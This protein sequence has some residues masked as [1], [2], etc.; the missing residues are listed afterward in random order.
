MEKIIVPEKLK[1]NTVYRVYFDRDTGDIFSI[2]N[3]FDNGDFFETDYE[4]VKYLLSG[5]ERIVDYKVVYNIRKIQYEIVSKD[6]FLIDI[7][8]ND[9]IYKVPYS[10]KF[11]IKI[12]QNIKEKKWVF[13]LNEETKV[14]LENTNARLNEQLFFSVTQRDNPNILYRTFFIQIKDLVEN[15]FC[16]FEFVD[17]KRETTDNVSVYTNRKFQSYSHEVINE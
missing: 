14:I 7:S 11:Q 13:L 1:L 6:K 17:Q 16:S 3:T 15:Q 2:T 5:N 12:I 4:S 8:V 9:I 10:E